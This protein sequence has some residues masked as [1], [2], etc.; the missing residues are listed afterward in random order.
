MTISAIVVNQGRDALITYLRN[1]QASPQLDKF[2]LKEFVLLTGISGS[3][4]LD[5]I[6]DESGTGL[7][8]S[9]YMIT[10]ELDSV[11]T[12]ARFDISDRTQDSGRKLKLHCVIP[13]LYD[14][15]GTLITGLA[16]LY[17]NE[18]DEVGLFGYMTF[19]GQNKVS[20]SDQTIFAS[21]QF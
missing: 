18:D 16:V 13:T 8:L 15:L 17:K 2:F 14:T 1:S 10:G 7:D 19:D 12:D 9:Q 5:K 6:W 21:V 11:T 20:G 3:T 4:T